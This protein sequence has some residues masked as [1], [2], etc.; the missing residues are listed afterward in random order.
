MGFLLFFV[1]LVVLLTIGVQF[2]YRNLKS[3]NDPLSYEVVS[4]P[5]KGTE[6]IVTT[7]DGTKLWTVTMGSGARTVFMA[8]G[9]GITSREWNVIADKLLAQGY[10]LIAFDQRGHG[11]STIGSQGISSA[12]MA[13]DTK[14]LLEHFNLKD[15][16]LLAH[17][18]GTFLSITF[19]LTYPDVAQRL[20]A[21]VLMSSFAGD[22]F[23]GSPQ[24]RLQITLINL[25]LMK[26]ILGSQS[27]GAVLFGATLFGDNPSYAGV[28]VFLED[29]RSNDLTKLVPILQAFGHENNYSKVASI[30]VPI[31]VICGRKDK[32]T[33]PWHTEKLASTIPN[34]RVAWIEG[35]GHV[36]N[37]ESPDVVVEAVKAVG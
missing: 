36:L 23:N 4:Q 33:P 18:M 1:A 7:A 34:A 22:I 25:G 20:K 17:S 27:M 16:I 5:L 19:L 37:W 14:T 26:Y 31:T 32:T 30:S 6:E 10:K 21:A 11:K 8:H 15:I 29:I 35:A 9:Y 13:S 12:A 2:S 3:R 28:R 24:S